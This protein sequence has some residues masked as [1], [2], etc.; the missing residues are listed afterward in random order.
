MSFRKRKGLK[1]EG[2]KKWVFKGQ[3]LKSVSTNVSAITIGMYSKWR[4]GG[5]F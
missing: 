3:V 5:V 1:K 2:L 4:T